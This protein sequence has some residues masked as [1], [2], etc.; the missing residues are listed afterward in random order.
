MKNNEKEKYQI[1]FSG[2]RTSAYM[3]KLLLDNFSDRY[4]FIVTFANT[5]LEN[6]K[7]LEFVNN[8]DKH[9]GFNTIWLEAV[10]D[11]RKMKGTTHKVVNFETACRDDSLFESMIE[12]Y[13]I[14]NKAYPHCTRELKLQVM[15]S[16]L[17]S[18]G[19]RPSEVKTA[20]GIRTDEKRRV[21]KTHERKNIVYPLISDFPSDKDDVNI[22]WENQSFDLGMPEY[23]GNC[24]VC[25]KKSFKKLFMHLDDS[26]DCIGFHERMERIHP[27]TNNKEGY[28]D[29][30]FFRQNTSTKKLIEMWKNDRN[31]NDQSIHIEDGG[32]SESCEIYSTE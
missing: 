31:S 1:S 16:Y 18:I 23:L 3:T 5:G 17:R 10:I 19:I 27:Q 30:V 12:K 6:E 28:P 2:G 4:E 26:I 11:P 24:R 14:P 22:F 29:R 7:T 21:S 13:G 25:F 20:I 9:F 32:C 15:E 8:C